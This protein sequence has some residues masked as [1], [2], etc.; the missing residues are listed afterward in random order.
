M[1]SFQQVLSLIPPFTPSPPS[2]DFP[3]L[4]RLYVRVGEMGERVKRESGEPECHRTPVV[5]E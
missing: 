2:R 4:S 5:H 3:L 1:Y